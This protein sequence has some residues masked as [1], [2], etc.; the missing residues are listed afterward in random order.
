MEIKTPGH[1]LPTSILFFLEK[2]W[3]KRDSTR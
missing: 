3:L 1:V 2:N